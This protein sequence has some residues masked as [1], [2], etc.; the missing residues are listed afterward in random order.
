MDKGQTLYNR[1]LKGAQQK[2]PNF[3]NVLRNLN[4]AFELGNHHAAWALG[5][6]YLRGEHVKQDI[7]KAVKLLRYASE[8]NIPDAMYD[9]AVCIEK[10]QGIKKDE[11]QA[12]E[13]YLRA[14]LRGFKH[15]FVEVGRCYYWGIGIAED[16]HVGELWFDRSKEIDAF[17]SD[18]DE[19]VPRKAAELKLVVHK[20][21]K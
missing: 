14:A 20:P 16:K 15:A 8:A 9:L 2:K 11:T 18:E 7:K 21:E 6:W 13:L 17:R 10:G 19:E 4:L 5:A 12:F 3:A 1:A